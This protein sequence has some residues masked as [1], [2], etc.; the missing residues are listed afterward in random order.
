MSAPALKQDSLAAQAST[1]HEANM[2]KHSDLASA[3]AGIEAKIDKLLSDSEDVAA[4]GQA[5]SGEV[6]EWD[7]TSE[8][9][10]HFMR[11]MQSRKSLIDVVLR[12]A[13][14]EMEREGLA[15]KESIYNSALKMSATSLDGMSIDD[16]RSTL[17]D[18]CKDLAAAL[19]M[20]EL[21]EKQEEKA[22]KA[23][24]RAEAKAKA[25]AT[26]KAAAEAKAAAKAKGAAKAKAKGVAKGKAKAKA[27]AAD[28]GSDSSSS[29]SPGSP[30][31][32]S[33]P[34]GSAAS[35]SSAPS[36]PTG[37][38]SA[39]HSPTASPILTPK[40]SPPHSPTTPASA[41]PTP[42]ASPI[43]TPPT[44]PK[45]SASAAPTPK[46]SPILTPPTSPKAAASAA[47]TPKAS[48]PAHKKR[49]LSETRTPSADVEENFEERSNGSAW[50]TPVPGYSAS[51]VFEQNPLYG[52]K[53]PTSEAEMSVH[54]DIP[55]SSPRAE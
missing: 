44:S 32:P 10:R 36:S 52:D 3:I 18:L 35:S 43:L 16:A 14:D 31:S 19:R 7:P 38:A 21:K 34:T 33:S 28:G 30:A 4:I 26:A 27:L 45:A 20:R 2:K 50:F 41:A 40:A 54:T 17:K 51:A 6:T 8:S 15:R 5:L 37:S 22:A 9:A 24:E 25:K 53:S 49:R 46:A 23:R 11:K 13:R 1:Y 12:P 48:S 55:S 47:S 39:A 42:K 29:A